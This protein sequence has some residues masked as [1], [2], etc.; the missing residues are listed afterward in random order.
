MDILW[1]AR[2][3]N[4]KTGD[5]PT[6]WIGSSIEEA[7]A[8]CEGCDLLESGGCYAHGGTV[9]MG[10]RSIL[11]AWRAGKRERYTLQAAL[12]GA[13]RSARMARLSAIGDA[14]RMPRAQAEAMR[15]K[16]KRAG[17]ALVGYTHHWREASVRDTWRGFLMASCETEA[18]ADR[19]VS[20]G[21]RA[22]MI[23]P[24]WDT[25]RTWRTL[26]G[27]KVSACPAQVTGGR[28]TCNDCLL[29]DAS[30]ALVPIVAFRAHGP[31]A[32]KAESTLARAE[33]LAADLV[34]LA[35][36]GETI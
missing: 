2:T 28:V 36:A 30:R 17:L 33:E 14:G 13:L 21:W 8:S 32:T 20:E 35:Q 9:A 24:S 10:F 22:T 16:I 25:R 1:T 27:N 5:V 3:R 23:V 29:C 12:S 7:R 6:A 31:G 4:T 15:A 34:A 18:Q 11:R 19:A 26:A